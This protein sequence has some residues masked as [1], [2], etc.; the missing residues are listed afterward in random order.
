MPDE[1]LTTENSRGH[2]FPQEETGHDRRAEAILWNLVFLREFST[3][4]CSEDTE[5]LMDKGIRRVT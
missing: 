2:Q 3:T 5:I 4:K 1:T